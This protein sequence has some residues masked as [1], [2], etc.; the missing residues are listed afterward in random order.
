MGNEERAC[1]IVGDALNC[2]DAIGIG[3]DMSSVAAWASLGHMAI[4]AG[5]V[6]FFALRYRGRRGEADPPPIF[7]S[8]RLETVWFVVPVVIV[9]L[10][11]NF[12]GDGLRDAADPY[13]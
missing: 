5:M 12:M 13:S 6:T 4:V 9:V 3:A 7:G 1:A 2:P 8:S 10:A 11:F